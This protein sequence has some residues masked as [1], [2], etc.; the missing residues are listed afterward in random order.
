MATTKIEW[1]EYSWNPVT[2]CTKCSPGCTNCYAEKMAKRLA[3]IGA[4][5]RAKRGTFSETPLWK[6]YSSVLGW[7]ENQGWNGEVFCDE[8]ALDKPLHWRKPRRIFVCS[9]SDLFHEKVPF[10]YIDEVFDMMF[11]AD[12]HIYQL[13]TKRIEQMA[14]YIKHLDE[15]IY[16]DMD[17][18]TWTENPSKHIH[19]GVSISTQAEA[20]EKIPILLQIPAAVRWVS[21]EPML[22]RIDLRPFIGDYMTTPA[23]AMPNWII[24][25]AESIGSRPGRECKLDD[26]R[27]LVAQ[28]RA[29]DVA[30]LVKQ[31]HLNGKLIKDITKFPKDIRIR[32]YP[33]GGAK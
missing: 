9:M 18:L 7:G 25:G 13:L 33:K 5:Q 17:S 27:D 10:E 19:L 20:D 3:C 21:V 29:A 23:S 24:I 8:T 6:K 28:C 15:H 31:I 12:W 1:S 30:V 22:E 26:V 14:K 32:E 16:K 2:G 11:Y 4:A